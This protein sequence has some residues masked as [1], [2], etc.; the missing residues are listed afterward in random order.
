ME[1]DE[2]RNYFWKNFID[3]ININLGKNT[4]KSHN[5][6]FYKIFNLKHLLSFLIC[7][8]Y[9]SASGQ[10]QYWQQ[11]VNYKINVALEDQLHVLNG[12][13]DIE[14]INNSPY[15]L[16]S[17]IFHL[18][19]NAFSSDSTA[20][21]EQKLLL[22]SNQ[23]Y[24]SDPEA[25]GSIS[26]LGFTAANKNLNWNHF[27]GQS[28]IAV[29]YL[30]ETLAPGD[31]I[32]IS[33]PFKVDLPQVFSRLGHDGQAYQISQWYPKPAVFDEKGWHP[34][35]YLNLG[36]YYAEFGNYDVS[37]TLPKNY[38]VAATGVLQNEEERKWLKQQDS[39]TRRKYIAV[40][41]EDEDGMLIQGFNWMDKNSFPP[42]DN[43][44][45]TLRFL[46]DN[47]PDFAWFADKRYNVLNDHVILNNGQVVN[48]WSFF[49]DYKGDLWK[50]S[51]KYLKNSV[52]FISK[53]VGAYPYEHVTA[54][55]GSL[56]EAAGGME[57]P[58]ITLIGDVSSSRMLEQ[59][60]VH[61]VAHNWFQAMI[62]T[63]ERQY[64]WMDE[65]ITSYYEN[66][67]F[68]EFYP[69]RT[70]L[71]EPLNQ[72]PGKAFNLEGLTERRLYEFLLR[73]L[74]K[75]NIDQP[76]G[77]PAADFTELNLGIGV[78]QKTSM[79]LTHLK[80]YLG[81][82]VFNSAM[83][84][85]FEKWKFKHPYPEDLKA[86]F[87]NQ[88]KKGQQIDWLFEEVIKT[89][90]EIDYSIK[91]VKEQGNKATIMLTNKGN[92]AAPIVVDAVLDGKIINSKWVNGFQ[93][94]TIFDMEVSQQPDYYRI[95]AAE[96]TLDI[97][98]QNNTYKSQSLFSK[99]NKIRFQ[100]LGSVDDPYK[101]EI[102]F[103]P[104]IAWN[105]YDRW[106]VGLALYNTLFE[107][108]TFEY[109][110]L[111]LYSF[112]QK[113][114]SGAGSIHLNLFP[115]DLFIR[116][117]DIGL[118][119]K[120]FHY[121]D[122]RFDQEYFKIEPSVKFHLRQRDLREKKKSIIE[123]RHVN[124]KKDDVVFEN[125]VF[126]LTSTSYYINEASYSFSN[127]KVI[128]PFDIK[129]TLQ[130]HE[131]FIKTF[132]EANFNISLKKVKRG[133]DIRLF[134]GA[135]LQNDLEFPN[136]RMFAFNLSGVPGIFDYTFD[137]YYLG[138][139]EYD[140]ILYQQL[141]EQQGGL[142]IR[143]DKFPFGHSDEWLATA[144]IKV[145]VPIPFPVSVY[146]EAGTTAE[147]IKKEA[148]TEAIV[149]DLGLALV[150]FPDIFE[151]YFPILKSSDLNQAFHS[152]GKTYLSRITFILNFNN[153]NPKEL[154]R[155]SVY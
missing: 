46:Q 108:K 59:V 77:A 115:E 145:P 23:F 78:Y 20:F 17:L 58:M 39:I 135:F 149:W 146:G 153:L 154:I 66:L 79:A 141:Y 35:P 114:I 152:E 24:Y 69:N 98:R 60:I 54:V 9:F 110:L 104:L 134:A 95:D 84:A 150:P 106:M 55:E 26:G 10:Q 122:F 103:L 71:P 45:K 132:A 34:M 29:I 83:E 128:N 42:S 53:K 43:E 72:S 148:G 120:S 14:Y 1:K 125:D 16:D 70:L 155:K 130:Q 85:Y 93:K 76:V 47:V 97:N 143:A 101:T 102:Y 138:R 40:D 105:N 25:R 12:Y 142:K 19:P 31:S 67:Y 100:F 22:G 88:I 107:T 75:Q 62:G 147:L 50:S 80:K 11:Q 133:I 111:P 121:D 151:I 136:E 87:Q 51:P 91:N 96:F 65:G 13:I 117:F 82:E 37:I 30:N 15:A 73:D 56:L 61:E 140:G 28:D 8:L 86:V 68:E 32:T 27:N 112:T 109:Q 89:T 127:Q 3:L 49:T 90:G 113:D 118:Q 81:E 131:D 44:T 5:F 41:E 6:V 2:I 129:V 63:N 99:A 119:V 137:N 48:V 7:L 36:E 123:L 126:D 33:T 139:T 18:W 4:T 52:E 38:K 116:Q 124:I 21:A 57:Y 64:P 74:S 94:D 144:I 92:I